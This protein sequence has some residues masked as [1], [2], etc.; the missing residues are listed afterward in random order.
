MMSRYY[1]RHDDLLRNPL[2]PPPSFTEDVDALRE[3]IAKLVGKVALPRVDQQAHPITKKLLANEEERMRDAARGW[4]WNP[5]RYATPIGKRRLRILNALLL[6]TQRLGCKPYVSTSR[7]EHDDS[8]GSLQIGNQPVRF[9]LKVV[10]NS[11]GKA[12]IK[13]AKE[14]LRLEIE[15]AVG[16]DHVVSQWDDSGDSRLEEALTTVVNNMFL[17]AELSYRKHAL[18]H[19]GYLIRYKAELEE[20]ERQ[21]LIDEERAAQELRKRQEQERVERLLAQAD[22]LHQAETIRR[23]VAAVRSNP[24]RTR[25]SGTELDNWAT[26]ALDQADCID[27][28]KTLAFLKA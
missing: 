17:F 4:H 23:Y 26:W 14:I 8:G 7:Y 27:P 15:G 16:D 25:L 18:E 12:A 28:V 22:A 13:T 10:S 2:P 5:P 9:S 3:R 11:A 21:R 20:R 6:A 1:G 24:V 19:H